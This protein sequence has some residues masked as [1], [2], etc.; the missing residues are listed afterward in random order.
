[1]HATPHLALAF[2]PRPSSRTLAYCLLASMG[3]HIAVMV[4]LP[5]WRQT[6]ATPSGIAVLTARI[7]SVVA[8]PEPVKAT[9]VPEP[10][11]ARAP[12]RPVEAPRPLLT[13]P[14]DAP[15]TPATPRV[16]EQPPAPPVSQPAAPATVA[17]APV[18][19]SLAPTPGPV[20]KAPAAP[21]GP[22]QAAPPSD[23][24]DNGNVERFRLA[25]MVTADNI[26]TYPPEAIERGMRGDVT[27]RVVM[28]PDGHVKDI[29][30]V[31]P[32]GY[33]ILDRRAVQV[34][35]R[36]SE[37]TPLPAGLAGREYAFSATLRF[38]LKE[39]S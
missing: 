13:L 16:A 28:G 14:A 18:V 23:T 17:P 9:P 37:A 7:A 25:V 33:G 3:V 26:K 21:P 20:A 1:M 10:E 32:S 8:P 19:P 24:A 29:Q 6:P 11:R 34:F 35:K 12:V 30:V 4:L 5:G 36:A 27:V 22:P 2:D 38:T 39:G 31:K 15:V